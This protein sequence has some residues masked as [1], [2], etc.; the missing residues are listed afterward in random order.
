MHRPVRHRLAVRAAAGTADQ[1]LKV[2][3]TGAA[4]RTGSLV[5]KKLAAKP[6]EFEARAVVRGEGV[7]AGWEPWTAIT[8][9]L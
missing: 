9:R 3:V 2:V 1:P 5:V 7:G 8:R 4:G 6:A